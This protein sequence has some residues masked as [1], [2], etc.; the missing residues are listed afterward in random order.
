MRL[1]DIISQEC[2]SLL[3]SADFDKNH[4]NAPASLST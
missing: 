1:K 2:L 3:T 4:G